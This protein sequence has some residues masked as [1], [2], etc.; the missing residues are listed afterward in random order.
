MLAGEI[1]LLSGILFLYIKATSFN[2]LF[3][4][5]NFYGVLRVTEINRDTPDLRAYLLSHGA[6]VHGLQLEASNKRRLPTTYF[7]EKSGIGLTFLNHPKR[8]GPIRVGIL[9]LGIGILASYAQAGD[10]V[11]FYEINPEVIR[12]AEGKGGYFTFLKDSPAQVQVM[13]GDARISLEQELA[14]GQPQHFDLIVLDTFNSD[15][16]PVHLIT[17]QAFEIYLRHLQPDGILALHISNNYLDLR[18]VV[19]NLS[20]DFQLGTALIETPGDG[21]RAYLSTWMLVTRNLNFLNQAAI[22]SRNSPRGQN[23][24]RGFREWTDDYSNLFQILR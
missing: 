16:I 21:D 22:A 17:R 19:Y 7:T 23:D 10:T 20:D 6:T 15:S 18:P 8:P 12:L 9:G 4:S 24:T 3:A 1:V 11:R 5:R 13:A 2:D 14:A